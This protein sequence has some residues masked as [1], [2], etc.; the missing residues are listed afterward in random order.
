MTLVAC[1][2]CGTEV[3]TSAKACPKCGSK[4]PK[5]KWWL[6]VPL[7][8]GAAFL[9]FGAVVGRSPEAQGKGQARRAIDLCWEEQKR[10]SFDAG[11]QNFVAGAC[12]MMEN[13]FTERY[14]HRP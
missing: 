13:K 8:L 9:L 4:V 6:W 11:T 2:E 3:S 1:K 7:G 14:G 12:E 5:T 10:K